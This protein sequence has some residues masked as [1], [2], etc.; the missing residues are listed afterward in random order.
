MDASTGRVLF[1]RELNAAVKGLA[2]DPA[3][4]KPVGRSTVDPEDP[5]KEVPAITMAPVSQAQADTGKPAISMK[6]LNGN[7]TGMVAVVELINGKFIYDND[8][9]MVPEIDS[10]YEYDAMK[11]ALR[12]VLNKEDPDHSHNPVIFLGIA[13]FGVDHGVFPAEY[14]LGAQKSDPLSCNAC[15]NSDETKNRY[16]PAVA[17]GDFS[18]GRF[19]TLV[20][21]ALPDK[22][23]KESKAYG[24]CMFQKESQPLKLQMVEK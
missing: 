24:G 15:H 9:D 5:Q 4:G 14:A 7:D 21:F 1:V 18:A 17:S 6:D 22:A 8:G 16:S 19:V 10:D 3:T 12:Q 23:I 11:E 2:V 13:P 20:P